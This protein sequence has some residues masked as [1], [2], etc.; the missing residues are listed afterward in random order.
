MIRPH[1]F[2]TEQ[3][4]GHFILKC[5]QLQQFTPPWTPGWTAVS[6]SL[7]QKSSQILQ[8]EGALTAC[9]LQVIYCLIKNVTLQGWEKTNTFY[10]NLWN[11]TTCFTSRVQFRHLSIIIKHFKIN[12]IIP[13]YE[14]LTTQSAFYK[15]NKIIIKKVSAAIF[16]FLVWWSPTYICIYTVYSTKNKLSCVNCV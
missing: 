15:R 10:K 3:T 16:V 1:Q 7:C 13:N 9:E 14:C 11:A 8:T 12:L 5:F 6:L 2:T 4:M